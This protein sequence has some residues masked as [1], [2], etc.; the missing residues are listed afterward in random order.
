LVET[1]KDEKNWYE[2]FSQLSKGIV[3]FGHLGQYLYENITKD[4]KLSKKFEIVFIWN[5]S[6]NKIPKEIDSSL[7]LEDLTKFSDFKPDII[8]EVAHPKITEKYGVEFL[9][10]S[11]K[12]KE[13]LKGKII[14]VVLLLLFQM[15]N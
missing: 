11:G 6:V 9:K 10:C 14:F 12:K 5:R 8:V 7:I 4:E 1:F 2:V 3:G 13:K 15:K